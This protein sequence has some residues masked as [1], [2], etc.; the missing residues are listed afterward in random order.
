M[1]LSV[2]ESPLRNTGGGN[3]PPPVLTRAAS[4]WRAGRAALRQLYRQPASAV[5]TT[6]FILFILIAL[7][8]PWLAPYGENQQIAADA[9][10][11]PSARHWFGVDRLGRDVF[12]RVLLGARDILSLAGL[13]TPVGLGWA[14]LIWMEADNT[15]T[16]AMESSD[17]LRQ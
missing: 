14:G 17:L 7:V 6:I 5:G 10:Q 16:F 11:A 4:P 12:S 13:G 3:V 15:I 8:G 2:S 9:R 1:S